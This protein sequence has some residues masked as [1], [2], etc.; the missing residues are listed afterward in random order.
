MNNGKTTFTKLENI[1]TIHA[2]TGVVTGA[3]ETPVNVIKEVLNDSKNISAKLD[4]VNRATMDIKDDIKGD[5]KVMKEAVDKISKDITR[6]VEHL[7][8]TK[9]DVEPSVRPKDQKKNEVENDG[10]EDLEIEILEPKR[11]KGIFFSSSIAL[12]CDAQKLS[13]DINSKIR[14]EKTYHIEKHEDAK[15]PEL[16]LRN[17]LN[18]LDETRD[19]DFL[20]ISVGSNDITR[21]DINEDISV[22]NDK[23]CELSK[24]LVHIANET[25]RKHNVDVFIVEKP[26]RFDKEA[27]DPEGIRSVLTVSSNGILPSLITPL[28]RVHL[29]SLPSLTTSADR[30]CFSRDGVH[31]TTKGEQLYHQDLVSGVKAV[32]SDLNMETI[33]TPNREKFQKDG[34]SANTKSEDHN[35]YTNPRNSRRHYGGSPMYDDWDGHQR[36][37][38]GPRHTGSYRRPNQSYHNHTS[39]QRYHRYSDPQY[40]Y[41]QPDNRRQY[42]GPRQGRYNQEQYRYNTEY[43]QHRYREQ[44]QMGGEQYST[45]NYQNYQRYY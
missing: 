31:L 36:D 1:T 27:K 20:I 12:Q 4:E 44:D 33:K 45:R 3:E 42:R 17:T 2:D 34:K 35:R 25:S 6:L 5:S 30:D 41:R 40:Q 32:Y 29:I 37:W 11:R 43:S 22:L 15:D 38:R 26:A 10:N 23:A 19:A 28:K 7:Q 24:T 16:F 9:S 13:N 8:E 21:L 39:E 18:I 14:I